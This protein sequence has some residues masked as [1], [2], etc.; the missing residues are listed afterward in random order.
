MTTTPHALVVPA[1]HHPGCWNL[2]RPALDS[3]RT[4]QDGWAEIIDGHGHVMRVA[5]WKQTRNV[6]G[7]ERIG[8]QADPANHPKDCAGCIHEHTPRAWKS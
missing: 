8:C 6:F 3:T 7:P 5:K 4:V 2:P 1:P